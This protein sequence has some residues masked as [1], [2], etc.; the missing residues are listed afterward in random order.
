MKWRY[1]KYNKQNNRSGHFTCLPSMFVDAGPGDA[2]SCSCS[3]IAADCS[4]DESNVIFQ[5]PDL[6]L[7]GSKLYSGKRS[8]NSS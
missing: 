2:F 3:Y 8:R 7:S 1:N 4:E 6:D 5:P